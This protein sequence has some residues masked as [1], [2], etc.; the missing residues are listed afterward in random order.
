MLKRIWLITI[1][2]LLGCA[3]VLSGCTSGP[4]ADIKTSIRRGESASG[5]DSSLA[6]GTN[7]KDIVVEM[8]G[9]STV[10]TMSFLNG[11]RTANVSES[12]ISSLPEYRVKLLNEPARMQVDLNIDYWDYASQSEW[13]NN[14]VIYGTFKTVFTDDQP[15]SIIF[16][17]N[18]NVEAVVE[19][20]GDKLVI[21]LTPIDTEVRQLY[22]A[23]VNAYEE[24]SQSLLSP[25]MGLTPTLCEGLNDIILISEPFTDEK[26]A[27]QRVE[28]INEQL[29][30]IA[31]TKEAYFIELESNSLPEY[32]QEFQQQT[33][34]GDAVMMIDGVPAALDVMV[35]NGKYLCTMPSG[36]IVYARSYLPTA[37]QDMEQIVKSRIWMIETSGKMTEFEL[38]DFYDIERAAPSADGKYLA[39]LDVGQSSKVLY[40]YDTQTGVLHNLGEEG[41]GDDTTSFV[42]DAADPVIYGMTGYLELGTLQLTKY[43]FNAAEGERTSS[44]EEQAGADSKIQIA[45]DLI[46]FADKQ[47]GENGLGEIY[48]VS[49]TTG[50]RT[51]VG[52]G[53]EFALTPDGNHLVSL[54][55][56]MEEDVVSFNLQ[57]LNLAAPGEPKM[58]RESVFLESYAF[59]ADSDTLYFTTR[60]YE[61]VTEEYPV[62]LLNYSISSGEIKLVGYSKTGLFVPG[63]NAGELYIINYSIQNFNNFYTTYSFKQGK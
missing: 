51:A 50:E 8:Q 52:Q 29:K 54:I 23:A 35:E 57:L 26:T 32:K 11:S 1:T 47:A 9:N 2:I 60:E 6:S 5:G 39:I 40:V 16:Q 55:P 3:L 45:G 25:E 33:A 56:S 61:G 31:P 19:E 24:F 42:W 53:I 58:I 18:A 13:F 48:S 49:R 59:G 7:L 20:Q 34:A 17:L 43:D 41:F 27:Q 21:K 4:S 30:Q 10:I 14:S 63:V 36:N 37:Q 46:Y 22:F 38:P 28:T 12:K 62:A 44:I 15:V